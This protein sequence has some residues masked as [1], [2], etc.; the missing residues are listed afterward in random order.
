MK[1]ALVATCVA[2]MT[3]VTV[4]NASADPVATARANAYAIDV[5]GDLLNDLI[6]REPEVTSVFPPGSSVEEDVVTVDGEDL[7]LEAVGLVQAETR[8]ESTIV[9]SLRPEGEGGEDDSGLLGDLLGGGDNG[10]S[11]LLGNL[12]GGD[13][14]DEGDDDEDIL[15]PAAN[16]RGFAS[17]NITGLLLD[18]NGGG[19]G[20]GGLIGDITGDTDAEGI[21]TR[22]VFDAL[23]RLGVLESEAVAVCS[24]DQVF[25][26]VAS[27]IVDDQGSD[28]EIGDVLDDAIRSVVDIFE[29][30]ENDEALL[31]G[32]IEIR[33]NEFGVTP[34]GNG[35]FINALHITVGDDIGGGGGGDVTGGGGGTVQTQQIGGGDDG[36]NSVLGDLF[37]D[38][39]GGGDGGDGGGDEP[40]LDIVLAHSEVSATSCAAPPAPPSSLVPTG[41]PGPS[42]PRTGGLGALPSI[43][44]VGL[45]GGALGAGRLAL[46]ARGKD[47]TSL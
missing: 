5:G 22:V 36:E 13:D 11:G 8:A 6:E 23:L 2:A 38:L 27:R 14:G 41:D 15:I 46:R 29:G 32:L 26:D 40:L 25:F 34:D 28:I 19:G 45:L 17:I 43:L 4:T 35:V 37:G 47:N 18:D 39:L 24:G 20:G 30:D 3:A 10:D 12:L 9:P 16:A 33:D 31:S 44:G 42:L 1:K 21:L 7:L